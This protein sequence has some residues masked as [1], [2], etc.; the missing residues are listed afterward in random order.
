NTGTSKILTTIIDGEALLNDGS[1]IVIYEVLMEL[2]MPGKSMTG[3][4]MA[5][6]FCR[7]A[8]G[9]PL[10]G[11]IMGKIAVWSLS[12]VFNDSVI[13]ITITLSSAYVTYYLAENVFYVSGVLAVV[14]L[15]VVISANK[16]SISP[17]VEEF[18]HSFWEM[19]SYLA[20][21]LIFIIVGVVITER[22]L[23]FIEKNDLFL[24]LITYIGITV[25]R[26]VMI[27][28]LSPI[29]TRLGYGLKWQDAVVMTWGGLRGAVG[30][31]LALSVAESRYINR[32][33]IGNKV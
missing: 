24:I 9:G 10:L 3:N 22:S 20:N 25:F 17:E 2:A 26:L 6:M 11:F 16:V 30:L 7:I 14:A 27:G 4:E 5:W 8:F 21:T 15:G 31:A 19:L 29:L 28:I 32:D 23:S 13:E 12:K 18:V 1:A 33:T